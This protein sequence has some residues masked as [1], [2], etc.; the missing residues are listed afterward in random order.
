MLCVIVERTA[1][2][3][4]LDHATGHLEAPVAVVDLAAFD[5]NAAALADR[6]AGKPIRVA[7]KSVRCRALLE[8]VLTRPG[9][10][11]V[12]AYTLPE[13][14]WLVRSGV[15]DDVLV[16]YPTVDRR[17]IGE[18]GKDPHLAAAIT[19]MVDHLGHVDLIDDVMA[20]GQRAELRLCIDL[21]ASWRPRRA[22]CTSAYAARP[23]TRPRRPARSPRNWSPAGGSGWS[24]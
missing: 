24:D 11:G 10:R 20:P 21:D 14:I 17:A 16:A 2:R 23:C 3:K 22:G 9:W 19:L 12:M 1:L 13:A 4:R 8:R 5:A 15:T 6:A 7:S 18:L